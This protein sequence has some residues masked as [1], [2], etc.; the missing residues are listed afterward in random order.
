MP[1]ASTASNAMSSQLS[2]VATTN[3]LIIAFHKLSK[4][5]ARFFHI[6]DII[7]G[8]AV[9]AASATVVVVVVEVLVVVT[10]SLAASV[11]VNP[12]ALINTVV[13][14][15]VTFVDSTSMEL[16]IKPAM[17]PP[18]GGGGGV[19]GFPMFARASVTFGGTNIPTHASLPDTSGSLHR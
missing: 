15:V 2:M 3:K 16:P 7:C 12:V 1:V 8:A 4:L 19:N 10:L 14:A 13:V 17:P 5:Y 9:V 6:R 18:L 11:V